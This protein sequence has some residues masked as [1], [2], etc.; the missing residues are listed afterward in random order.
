MQSGGTYYP[1]AESTAQP[2]FAEQAFLNQQNA[3]PT[4]DTP[5]YRDEGTIREGNFEVD[6]DNNIVEDRPSIL[7]MAANPMA[8]ARAIINPAVEGLPSQVE[9]DQSKSKGNLI[10]QAANDI[11]NPAAWANYGVNALQDFGQA[12]SYALQGEGQKAL[13]AA[14]S[15]AMNVLGAV[16]GVSVSGGAAKQ[17]L[18]ATAGQAARNVAYNMVTPLS[19]TPRFLSPKEILKNVIDPQGRPARAAKWFAKDAPAEVLENSNL[20]QN[21][22]EQM[23][24]RLDAFALGLGKTPRY[25]TLQKTG[26]NLYEPIG[27]GFGT[28]DPIN[29]MSGREV[30]KEQVEKGLNERLLM[31]GTTDL[32]KRGSTIG[33]TDHTYGFMGGYHLV[34][35]AVPT[36]PLLRKITMNDTWDLHPFQER[37][38]G[39]VAMSYPATKRIWNAI[40]RGMQNTLNSKL[41]NTEVLSALGGKPINIQSRWTA[42]LPQGWDTQKYKQRMMGAPPINVHRV[43][44]IKLTHEPPSFKTGGMRKMQ[45]GTP[46]KWDD[47]IQAIGRNWGP[48]QLGDTLDLNTL[49]LISEERMGVSRPQAVRDTMAY[50]ETGPHQRMQP[51]AVQ[52]AEEKKTGKEVPGVG[53]GLFMYDQPSTLR[54]ANRLITIAGNMG[55]E[56]PAFARQLKASDGTSRADTL[57]ADQQHMLMT[58][59]LIADDKAPFR[60]Y[61]RGDASLEDLWYKGVNR[62]DEEAKARGEFRESMRGLAQDD[63]SRY[64][65]MGPKPNYFE[66]Q[67]GGFLGRTANALNR[68]ATA[69]GAEPVGYRRVLPYANPRFM[70]SGPVYLPMYR[71]EQF[72]RGLMG[73]QPVRPPQPEYDGPK[74]KRA[75][76]MTFGA[77]PSRKIGKRVKGCAPGTGGYWCQ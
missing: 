47:T 23:S 1:V 73:E 31:S 29:V 69:R 44:N 27:V 28:P 42:K 55:M 15:G 12:G 24:R 16:P 25:N 30:L 17:A 64:F 34:D 48:D 66:R 59:N 70:N 39:D 74:I 14:G 33:V 10:G 36:N 67:K 38:V 76:S 71:G 51:N 8:T 6:K 61:G 53:R 58:A 72:V 21:S 41:Q 52:I 40:P 18:N 9:F 22:T 46:P 26:D 19:Y 11:V 65:F 54:D 3:L 63:L 32:G 60:A 77:A 37:S 75:T 20:L 49:D 43:G 4:L 56:A 57:S 62:R 68:R 7:E 5:R 2:S 13:Q 45:A 35:E 50:H